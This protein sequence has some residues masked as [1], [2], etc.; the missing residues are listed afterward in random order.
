MEILS[1]NLKKNKKLW[2][3]G[4][5]DYI[6]VGERCTVTTACWDC[7]TDTRLGRARTE[8]QH[9]SRKWEEKIIEDNG[10][11]QVLSHSV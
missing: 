8:N 11:V 6:F 4:T 1:G 3:K 5:E 2:A 7:S 10:S 9:K